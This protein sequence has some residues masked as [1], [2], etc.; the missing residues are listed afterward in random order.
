M[1]TAKDTL[2]HMAELLEYVEGCLKWAPDDEV[3][4]A[5]KE[6][7]TEIGNFIE[8]DMTIVEPISK[9]G[10]LIP[11]AEFKDSVEHTAFT[12]YDGYGFYANKEGRTKIY[13]DLWAVKRKVPEHITH[14]FWIN[15]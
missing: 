15:K 1:R 12:D 10:N 14:V 2:S 11:L 3:L 6:V 5:K 13:V 7:I 4:K 8:D 9:Y